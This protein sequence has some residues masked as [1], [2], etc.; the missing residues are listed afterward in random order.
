MY[1]GNMHALS[2]EKIIQLARLIELQLTEDAIQYR[3]ALTMASHN[4]IKKSHGCNI[5]EEHVYLEQEVLDVWI[6]QAR[7]A[8]PARC[9]RHWGHGIVGRSPRL[10]RK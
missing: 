9:R 4:H 2:E 5:G 6:T 8:A 1:K 3:R 10:M 7:P